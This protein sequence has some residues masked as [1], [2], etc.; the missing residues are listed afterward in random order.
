NTM[1]RISIS[2]QRAGL[3]LATLLGTALT[4]DAHAANSP[5]PREKAVGV[6][7]FVS[8]GVS[9]QSSQAFK[10]AFRD[11][12]LV[13]Q[14]FEQDHGHDVYTADARVR[15]VDAQGRQVLEERADGPFMLVRLPAGEYRVSATLGGR[16][17]APHAVHVSEHGHANSVFVFP[18]HTG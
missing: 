14:L 2:L 4:L 1:S 17:L 18:A 3:A 11:Y 16:S 5:L 9:L 6:A 10:R 13:I 15:I 8:G 7:S 12:P